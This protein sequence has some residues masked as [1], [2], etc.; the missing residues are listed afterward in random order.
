MNRIDWHTAIPRTV[1]FAVIAYIV[2][3]LALVAGVA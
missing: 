3:L 1:N 2:Y